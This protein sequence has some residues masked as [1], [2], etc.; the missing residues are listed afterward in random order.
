MKSEWRQ[1]LRG[2][3]GRRVGISDGGLGAWGAQGRRVRTGP[4]ISRRR[5]RLVVFVLLGFVMVSAY[6]WPSL[7]RGQ[8]PSRGDERRNDD[9]EGHRGE[10]ELDRVGVERHRGERDKGGVNVNNL[11]RDTS[12]GFAS[13][14]VRRGVGDGDGGEDRVRRFA[15]DDTTFIRAN[16]SSKEHVKEET[17]EEDG[18]DIVT[19]TGEDQRR[20]ENGFIVVGSKARADAVNRRREERTTEERRVPKIEVEKQS[21]A[22]AKNGVGTNPPPPPQ[23]WAPP[24]LAKGRPSPRVGTAESKEREEDGGIITKEADEEKAVVTDHP[25][26]G[27][28]R[29][30]EHY[31]ALLSYVNGTRRRRSGMKKVEVWPMPLT[32]EEQALN[33]DVKTFRDMSGKYASMALA[34]CLACADGSLLRTA[35]RTDLLC[36]NG[37]PKTPI[38]PAFCYTERF[39]PR[40]CLEAD[41][42][43]REEQR[44]GGGRFVAAFEGK[45]RHPYLVRFAGGAFVTKHGQIYNDDVMFDFRGMCRRAPLPAIYPEIAKERRRYKKVFVID[46]VW[47][48]IHH[49]IAEAGG[50]LMGYYRELMDDPEIYVHTTVDDSW[51]IVS[52][53]NKHDLKPTESALNILET[54]GINRSRVVGGDV[55]AEEEVVVAEGYCFYAQWLYGLYGSRL[56]N[57]IRQQ[58]RSAI[59]SE[60]EYGRDRGRGRVAEEGASAREERDGSFLARPY[61]PSSPLGENGKGKGGGGEEGGGMGQQQPRREHGDGNIVVVDGQERKRIRETLA[62]VGSDGDDVRNGERVNENE[63]RRRLLGQTEAR[64]LTFNSSSAD[65]GSKNSDAKE[66]VNGGGGITGEERNGAILT[67][68]DN[69]GSG[70]SMGST[71]LLIKRSAERR[72]AN[73]DELVEEL[74]KVVNEINGRDATAAAGIA[75][76][77]LLDEDVP[78]GK[79]APTPRSPSPPSPPPRPRRSPLSSLGIGDVDER[80]NLKAILAGRLDEPRMRIRLPLR[81]EVY[82]D[83]VR[84]SQV[85]VWALFAK[86][87]VIIGPHGAGFTN[88]LAARSGTILYEMVVPPAIYHADSTMFNFCFRM[89]SFA[90]GLDYHSDFPDEMEPYEFEFDMGGMKWNKQHGFMVVNASRVALNMKTLL[91]E[92]LGER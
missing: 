90:L 36:E 71:I 64:L 10:L 40:D 75:A 91:L 34:R 23:I 57:L 84:L 73:H 20:N 58:A 52:E 61:S 70:A 16:G 26:F 79:A 24:A 25:I 7:R 30:L 28:R 92:R 47:P 29:L 83:S 15:L 2:V 5:R 49:E 21:Q 3:G 55:Y 66:G 51:L 27:R 69:D 88:I 85:Q 76:S 19:T 14:D 17:E 9:V 13:N 43:M 82:D 59:T 56:R 31:D 68:G 62:V 41:R 65:D 53:E 89:M 12:K 77:R 4:L 42:Q 35:M 67:S 81:L 74:G 72:I 48:G 80:R 39:T 78:P 63:G 87:S 1:P 11:R 18:V 33:A 6:V 45:Q 50:Q 46:H 60:E 38:F 37:G 86:A 54:L 22:A 8:L 44:T 32:P